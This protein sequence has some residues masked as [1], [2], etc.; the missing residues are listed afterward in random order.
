MTCSTSSRFALGASARVLLLF[1]LAC[2]VANADAQTDEGHIAFVGFEPQND[3]DFA[4]VAIED[5][6]A[7]QVIYFI[8]DGGWDGSGSV[9]D[10]SKALTWTADADG[11]SAGEVCYF[12]NPKDNAGNSPSTGSASGNNWDLKKEGLYAYVGTSAGTSNPTFLAFVAPENVG[13][14]DSYV[15]PNIQGQVLLLDDNSDDVWYYSGSKTDQGAMR[16][17]LEK[18]RTWSNW[19]TGS[20]SNFSSTASFSVQSGTTLLYSEDASNYPEEHGFKDGSVITSSDK[21]SRPYNANSESQFSIDVS[22][23]ANNKPKEF[24][25]E[26][27]RND[28]KWKAKETDGVVKWIS[29]DIDISGAT[30]IS[31]SLQLLKANKNSPSEYIKLYATVGDGTAQLLD[32][33][34][35]DCSSGGTCN[36][37]FLSGSV[38][39]TGSTMTIEVWVS[40]GSDNKAEY[41]W[42][43][44]EVT[45]SVSVCSDVV[46]TANSPTVSLDSNGAVSI[47]AGENGADVT[48]SSTGDCFTLTG[49]E[50]SKTGPTTGFANSVSFDCSETGAQNIWVRATDGSA[51]SAATATTVTVQDV[52]PPT[53]G[54]LSGTYYLGDGGGSTASTRRIWWA[55]ATDGNG[56]NC[57]L[58]IKKVSK[59]GNDW[60]SATNFV[61]FDCTEL[62]QQTIYLKGTDA[63]GNVS[64]GS[65]TITIADNTL[66]TIVAPGTVNAATGSYGG[67]CSVPGSLPLGSPTTSDN[68]SGAS[69]TNDAPSS[70]TVGTTVVTWTVTDANGNT[71]TAT[72]DVV[73][74]DNQ[75]PSTPTLVNTSFQLNMGSVVVGVSD[76]SI[77]ASDNCTDSGS[78]TIE[79]S[80]D[81][82]SWGSA[83]SFG[84]S[85]ATGAWH[86]IYVRAKDASGNTSATGVGYTT[87]TDAP[88]QAVGQNVTVSLAANGT[89]TLTA[90][91]VDNGSSGNCSSSLSLSP[92]EFDCSDIGTNAVTL[93]VS[94]GSTSNATTVTVTVQDNTLPNAT[95]ITGGTLS[96]NLSDSGSGTIL[97]ADVY[98]AGNPLDRCTV[99]ENLEIQIKRVGGT[100]GSSVSVDCMDVGT[101]FTVDVRIEDQAENE[102]V[103][104]ANGGGIVTVTVNDVTAPTID[105]VTSGLTEN[106]SSGGAATI[107]ASA[108]ITASDNC[109]TSGSLVYEISELSGSGFAETFVADC[110]DLGAK[111]FYFRVQDGGANVSAVSS[112]TITIADVTDPTAVANGVSLFLS[113]GSAILSASDGTL[114]TSTDNCGI[115]TSE[116]KLS[117]AGD[118]TYASSLTFSS[119]GDYNVTLRVTDAAGNQAASTSTASVLLQVI[120]GCTDQ[121]ACNYDASANTDNGSCHFPGEECQSAA[122]GQGYVYTVNAAADGCDCT[123]QAFE[124]LYT[125]DF[126]DDP[127]LGSAPYGSDYCG[128]SASFDGNW[129][130]GCVGDGAVTI[131]EDQGW[132]LGQSLEAYGGAKSWSTKSIGVSGYSAYRFVSSIQQY[133]SGNGAGGDGWEAT[134]SI[135]GL[136]GTSILSQTLGIGNYQNGFSSFNSGIESTSGAGLVI[137]VTMT[138]SGERYLYLDNIEVEAWG[139]EGCTDSNAS[140]G[141]DAAAQVDD[142]SC[143]YAYETA[144]SRYDGGF[145]D[146]IWAGSTC[147]GDCGSA[148]HFDAKQVAANSQ[149]GTTSFD[150]VISTGTTVTVNGTVDVAG[151]ADLKDLFVHDLTIESGGALVIPSGKRLRVTGTYLDNSGYGISG[152][153]VLCIDGDFTIGTG[154]GSP[155]VVAVQDFML[156]PG[157]SVDVPVGKTLSIEGDL[158][159]GAVSPTGVS[160]L[161]E[162]AGSAAQ[163]ISGDGAILDDMQVSN[164]AGVAVSDSLKI[165]G[166]LSLGTGTSLTMGDALEVQGRL[167][168]DA[169]S[170]LAMGTNTLNFSSREVSGSPGADK[171]AVLD[172]IPSTAGI[173]GPVARLMQSS[174]A[175]PTAA[176]E[177]F[178]GPDGD[179]STNWGYT[180]FGT[181]ISG[182]TVSDFNGTDDFYSA[183]WPSSDYPNATS[184][185]SFWD[186]STGSIEYASSDS[187]DLSDRGCWVLLYGTQSPTMKTE[188]TLNNHQLGGANKVF[189]VTRQG[190]NALSAGWN[191][192]YNPYQARL[193]WDALY[194]AHSN[195]AVIEDQFLIFDTQARRFR[196]YGKNTAGVQWSNDLEAGEDSVA[197]RYVNPGQGFWVR[198]KSG[199]S[200]GSLTLDPSMIDND[201]TAV[202]F[203]RNAQVG[204]QEVLLEVSNANGNSRM[205]LRFG[206][207]GSAVGYGEG[208]LSYMGSSTMLG[209]CALVVGGQKYVAKNLPLEP[210]EGELFVRS[211]ANMPSVIRVLEVLGNPGICAH[212]E[213]HET[214][215]MMVL[216]PG[217]ELAFTLPSQQAEDGRFTLHS[218]PFG[219]VE[220]H[221]PHCPD[222]EAGMIEL[223]LGD[224]VAD[225]RV[226]NYETME[227]AAT[228]FQ[229][230]G[231]VEIPMAPGEYAVRIDAQEGTSKCRGGR[232][233]VS[234][235]PGEQPELLGL[236]AMPS[237]CNANMAALAFELYGAGGYVTTLMEGSTQIWSDTLPAGEHVLEGIAPSE[238]ILKVEH[239]CLSTYEFISLLD[240]Q[241]ADINVVFNG[242]VQAEPDGGAWLQATCPDCG[243]GE[244]YGY[245]WLLEGEEVGNDG[246]L[247]VHVEQ[248]GTYELE[249]VTYGM[250]CGGGTSFEITV[251]KYLQEEAIALEWLGLHAGQMGVR[252]PQIWSGTTYSWHDAT[253]RQLKSGRIS[254]ALGEVFLPTPN[255]R[256]WAVLEIQ[257]AQGRIGRWTGLLH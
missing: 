67:T 164:A 178:I 215:E 56:D 154:E 3:G 19:S 135:D 69:V 197:M 250:E 123:A 120:N 93:T 110:D 221:S 134:A 238:Y 228:L 227:V 81:A 217:A 53:I 29:R 40:N 232:R 207:G 230:T 65:G 139:K 167:T 16:G 45:G 42:T 71:A 86:P 157:S 51:T 165:Q 76:L 171:T 169:S 41:K 64:E 70:Y 5:I 257:S 131:Y 213:D 38:T 193:D 212:I 37:T 27:N 155:S 140:A 224:A 195:S 231:V 153:G 202:D 214:G 236:E 185:V 103:M 63:A 24:R 245:T 117:A 242:L 130:L 241:V 175:D 126:E 138:D 109:T 222:S 160:G 194:D 10:A 72:Q 203:V 237:E 34:F 7:N 246:P 253:G 96:K 151:N 60:E 92:T 132:T 23:T 247:S 35:D 106:L 89:Y 101:P 2:L 162:L 198:V 141:Y 52:T 216:E 144:Y 22:A 177:R 251:V 46:V 57:G 115:V 173:T 80:R 255:F 196:R 55:T 25:A 85:D 136:S 54:A 21:T 83:V 12:Q 58:A 77:S 62:G 107:S 129:T 225:I 182:A 113:G 74:T 90:A 149:T 112:E 158:T 26:G 97:P 47:S 82:I 20:V 229:K 18:L 108:F 152:E 73:V 240:E 88:L 30:G 6:P 205:L 17:Y 105:A 95:Q 218:I 100:W 159:F 137:T 252:F 66:P 172:A 199:V 118:E 163:T 143:V 166:Q 256:G 15:P 102:W 201:G 170:T 254:S 36:N 91:E 188:G 61:D 156:P 183:G 14:G 244:G 190:P 127:F 32:S 84:C 68:C 200:S 174:N 168:L 9:Y 176:V 44:L 249:L 98:I 206:P 181:S 128:G 116:V 179:G 248:W 150:Y 78:L 48:V 192:V 104:S 125:E 210:Y 121:T 233:Q 94:D 239:A 161:V 223:E 124:S 146:K 187:E 180:M 99:D 208:D 49:Y 133:Y 111:T 114:N 119:E 235:A 226:T 31:A 142:G 39:G 220:G 28:R 33:F 204:S 75:I 184:T 87:I 234:I 50:V 11:M 1:C 79:I 186:E 219:T 122:A 59:T 145:E 211:R 43:D 13:T 191:M 209:E 147:A 189:D 4:F 148:P 243:A 8:S